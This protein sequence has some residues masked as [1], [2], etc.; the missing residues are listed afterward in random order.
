MSLTK[1]DWL[2]FRT[3]LDPQAALNGFRGVFGSLGSSLSLLSRN[4]GWMGFEQSAELS[5]GGMRIGMVAFGG[6][7]QKGWC[8][9]NISGR[10]CEWVQDWDEATSSFAKMSAFETRRV[11]IALDTYRREVTHE[12]VVSAYKT[13]SFTTSGR[14]PKIT[15]ILPGERRDGRTVYIGS[16]EQGKFLRA[17]EKGFEL[18]KG[19]SKEMQVESIGG[20]P[21][22]DIYRL[23]LELKPKVS[24]L[25]VDLIQRRDQYFSGAYP[26][27]QSV[28]DIEPEIWHQKRE[29]GP[30]RDLDAALSQICHQ[31]GST[32]YTAAIAYHGDIGAVW[33]KVVGHKHNLSLLEKGVLL[34]DH[35]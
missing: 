22:E 25:P 27:L 19:Y 33:E 24:P 32:L 35:Q 4:R 3:K 31:Y 10:G 5:L 30:Q 12:T 2:G 14:P 6:E 13:G 18:V 11:D 21:I 7:N 16:R 8:S 9:V 20:F 17:Y 23:E 26:Y 28:V 34:V 1:V 15:E 29:E